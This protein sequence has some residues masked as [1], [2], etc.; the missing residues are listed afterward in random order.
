[1]TCRESLNLFLASSI[2]N[3][4]CH[5]SLS[6]GLFFWMDLDKCLEF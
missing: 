6:L 1:M 3:E 5:F 2:L 4:M